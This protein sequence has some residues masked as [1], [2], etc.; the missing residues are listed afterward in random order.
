[1]KNSLDYKYQPIILIGAGRSGTKIIRDVI[2]HHKDISVVPFDVNY[3][4][5]IGQRKENDALEAHDLTE[6]NRNLILKQF[7]KISDGSPFLLEKTVS[8]SLRIPYVLKVFPDAKILH[9]VRD[10]RDVVESVMR[11]WGEVRDA[12]YFVKKMKTFPIRYSLR[13]L[14]DY[15][16]NWFKHALGGKGNQ[17]YIW[18]VKY[19]GYQEDLANLPTLE[20]CAKQWMICVETSIRQLRKIDQSK[21]LEIRYEDL[22][23]DPKRHFHSIAAHIGVDTEG[24]GI[25]KLS[26]KNVGKHLGVFNTEQLKAVMSIM[27]PTLAKLNYR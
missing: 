13:Y 8:N 4:W 18:G 24:F 9:L 7:N 25:A 6:D 26:N 23:S 14:V 22:V 15:L 19:P 16:T 2:G 21:I 5:T 10:G 12:G 27:G 1:V 17:D 3:I 20:I 11:Q